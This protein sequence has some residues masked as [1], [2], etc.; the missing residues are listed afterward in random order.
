ML[1]I[2]TPEQ[3]TAH[4]NKVATT[5]YEEMM[6]DVSEEP[7]FISALA[8][9]IRKGWEAA[10]SD[11][12][13]VEYNML[14]CLRERKG[15][16][17]PEDRAEIDAAGGSDIY[18]KLASSKVRAGIAHIKSILLPDGDRAHGIEATKD[19]S[20]PDWINDMLLDRIMQNPLMVN[21][22]GVPVDPLDQMDLLQNLARREIAALTKTRARNMDRKITDQLQE[23]GWLNAM[24]Q[25]ID[26]VCTLPAGFMKGP[27]FAF[28]PRLKYKFGRGGKS[29]PET[30]IEQVMKFRTINPFDAYPAPGAETV[31]QGDFI[32]RLRMS[33][34]DLYRMQN[35]D[36]YNKEA[37]ADVLRHYRS[38][39]LTDWLWT[40]NQR[41]HIAEHVHHW[42]RA[43]TE[44]DGL[45]WYGKAQGFELIE[46]GVP[47][48]LIEDPLMEYEC[49]AILIGTRIVRAAINTNPMHRRIIDSTCYEKISGSVFGN[50]PSMLMRSTQRM[51]NATGRALQNN[52]AHAS[53]FQT[54]VDYLRVSAETDPF[55]IHPFKVW[56]TRESEHAGDRPA[57]R[58]FQPDSNAPELIN[59]IDYF[60]RMADNDTGIPE[61]LH[62][63]TGANTGA[64]ATAR[65]RAMLLDQSAKLLMSSIMNIDRDICM[66]KIEM[67]YNHNMK[68]DP[69]ED[70]KGDA[71]VVPKGINAR[72]Q[73][74]TARMSHM[75]LLEVTGN[76]PEARAIVGLEGRA[77]MLKSL[78]KTF[79]DIDSDDI[80]PSDEELER[81]IQEIQQQ[82]QQPDP[83]V[84]KVQQSAEEAQMRMQLEQAKLEADA[85]NQQVRAELEAQKLELERQSLNQRLTSDRMIKMMDRQTRTTV[86]QIEA[87][88]R[89][90]S[91]QVEAKSNRMGQRERAQL[92]I[93]KEKNKA[94]AAADLKLMEIKARMSERAA[95]QSTTTGA[96]DLTSSDIQTAVES[97]VVP[98]INTFKTDTTKIMD[99][100]IASLTAEHGVSDPQVINVNIDNGVAPT[101]KTI[102][103]SR[104]AS[105]NL[106]A[107]VTPT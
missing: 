29:T 27:Y 69:D 42:T 59:V 10:K 101:S 17:G 21:E 106:S 55:D 40:D 102:S 78:L 86:A 13:R 61:F 68:H 98:L 85:Q 43:T 47:R 95:T 33:R 99:D 100:L 89:V 20:L 30:T 73:L 97:V 75:A 94:R 11:K 50:S 56:Q 83:A 70:I 46:E 64:D 103:T 74:E 81:K 6:I 2:R 9:R 5:R 57:V 92:E 72:L 26:D 84:L 4:L 58:F 3:T 105:G 32:E 60:K 28:E 24:S 79:D 25:L 16:Y 90:E 44:L 19:P 77:K 96:V 48:E 51:V 41:S 36:G 14:E 38:G 65:G 7:R 104:D 23:G 18:I 82:Q 31:H 49:D 8:S 63:G 93:I 34:N 107:T 52:L 62:G 1:G 87:G 67:M 35:S 45:H 12:T 54:D 39:Y 71:Q 53:G 66:P 76:D 22:Q 80:I 91:M 37:I 88:G 15:E